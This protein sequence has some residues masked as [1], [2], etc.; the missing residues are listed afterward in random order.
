[1]SHAAFESAW[2]TVGSSLG[3]RIGRVTAT[4]ADTLTIQTKSRG[5]QTV[6][7]TSTTQFEQLTKGSN[8]DIAVGRRL[9]VT[10]S[11]SQVIVLPTSSKL[12][13]VVTSIAG[14]TVSLAKG[15][16]AKAGTVLITK[17]RLVDTTSPA[18]QTDFKTGSVV[19]AG[20]RGT[21]QNFNALEVILLPTGSSFAI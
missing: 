15:N 20:G 10:T 5:A 1:M 2:P 6:H 17:V 7:T 12:G 21:G 16:T 11:G 14:A 19:L 9:L 8:T 4:A 13:R 3:Q 18:P